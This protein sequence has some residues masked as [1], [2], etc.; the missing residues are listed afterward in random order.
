[1]SIYD[2]NRSDTAFRRLA[3]AMCAVVS[4]VLSTGAGADDTA[5]LSE[6]EPESESTFVDQA[7]ASITRRVA[8]TANRLDDFF[9]DDSVTE[10]A[11][12][13]SS[14][15]ARP[16][17]EWE[18]GRAEKVSLP[19]RIYLSLPQT[20]ARWQAFFTSD[21]ERDPDGDSTQT[22]NPLDA[23]SDSRS[24]LGISY[25]DTSEESRDLRYS[26]GAQFRSFQL[27]PYVQIR[28][29]NT[30][31]LGLWN[32]RLISKAYYFLDAGAEVSIRADLDREIGDGGLFRSSSLI[33]WY[34][35]DT[36]VR[37]NQG[38]SYRV[39]LGE[40]SAAALGYQL[41]ARIEPKFEAETHT[42]F[43]EYKKQVWR[44]WLFYQISPQIRV[45]EES[46]YQARAAIVLSLD[47]Y[48]TEDKI[49]TPSTSR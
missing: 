25:I 12:D 42:V 47:I 43:F 32:S 29:R 5:G 11:V 31:E 7:H 46:D 8:E 3:Q 4:V 23:E 24:E 20:E 15:R 18:D 10:E 38:F 45:R 14:L 19:L 36:G 17:L 48:F 1:M 16:T 33:E 2:S 13:L 37:F 41:N 49:S 27:D 30:S 21:S 28:S 9:G 26:I 39:L 34:E 44:D 6:T 22:A 35:L 40:K